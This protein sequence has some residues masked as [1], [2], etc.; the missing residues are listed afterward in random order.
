MNVTENGQT[1]KMVSFDDYLAKANQLKQR[2]LKSKPRLK[3]A[4]I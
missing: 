3:I 2:L 1:A 4:L